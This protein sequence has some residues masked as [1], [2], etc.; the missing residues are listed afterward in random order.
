MIAHRAVGGAV[1]TGYGVITLA[2]ARDLADFYAAEAMHC[3]REGAPAAARLCDDRETSL[4]AAVS[5][6]ALWRRAAGWRDPEAADG[7]W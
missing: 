4:R 1:T 2:R 6:A 7:P 3:R 5:A